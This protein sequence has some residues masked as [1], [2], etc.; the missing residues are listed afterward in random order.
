MNKNQT[1][2]AGFLFICWAMLLSARMLAAA[3]YASIPSRSYGVGLSLIGN[4]IP[5]FAW[6]SFAAAVTILILANKERTKIEPKL[7]R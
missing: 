6:L 1:I 5:F 3:I 4:W 2:L 7:D